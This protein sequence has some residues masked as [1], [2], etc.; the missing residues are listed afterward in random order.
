MKPNRCNPAT[1]ALVVKMP[2]VTTTM[3]LAMILV[4]AYVTGRWDFGRAIQK[5]ALLNC[6]PDYVLCLVEDVYNPIM[7]LHDTRQRMKVSS[8]SSVDC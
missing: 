8:G 1:V 2:K 4:I 3:L 5:L 7:F 6:L